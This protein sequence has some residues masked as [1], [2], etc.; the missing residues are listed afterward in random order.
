MLSAFAALLLMMGL[1]LFSAGT[2]AAAS[3]QPMYSLGTAG[4]CADNPH[5]STAPGTQLDQWSCDGGTNQKWFLEDVGSFDTLR[6]YVIHNQSSGLCMKV[7]GGTTNG[8]P[9]VLAGC[10]NIASEVWVRDYR[11]NGNYWF[12]NEGANLRCLT[13]EGA[14]H[15]NGARLIVWDCNDGGNELWK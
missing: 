6:K 4:M 14:S 11:G 9:V 13:V 12:R 5:F 3:Y 10:G 2:A 1:S 15:N 7:N 8:T